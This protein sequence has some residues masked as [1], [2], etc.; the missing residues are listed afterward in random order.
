VLFPFFSS[1]FSFFFLPDR[2]RFKEGMHQR[3]R[4]RDPFPPFFSP[5]PLFSPPLD[6]HVGKATPEQAPFPPSSFSSSFLGP[7][8]TNKG[9]PHFPRRGKPPSL[10]FPPLLF[11]FSPT[12]QGTARG[13]HRFSSIPGWGLPT[14]LPFLFFFFPLS[15]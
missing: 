15:L 3:I 5:P 8:M 7:P 12:K 4:D 6:L 9:L 11:F 14:F 1:S 2:K 10:F 13:F